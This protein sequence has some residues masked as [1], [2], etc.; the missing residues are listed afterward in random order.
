M[1]QS[2]LEQKLNVVIVLL[3]SISEKLDT[4]RLKENDYTKIKPQG[5]TVMNEL[6]NIDYE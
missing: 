2:K 3:T 4:L 5:F 6:G 1:E